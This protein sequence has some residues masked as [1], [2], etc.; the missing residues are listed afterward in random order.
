[1][2]LVLFTKSF[3]YDAAAEQTFILGELPYLREIFD[4]IILIPKACDGKKFSLNTHIDV[5]EGYAKFLNRRSNLLALAL[6]AITSRY[7]Y[8]E[9]L[10]YPKIVFAPFK[11]LKLLKFSGRVEITVRWMENWLK[12]SQ[13]DDRLVLYSYWF[14]DLAAGLT[15]VKRLYPQFKL[16]SRA[17]GYDIYEELYFPYYW[18]LRRQALAGLDKLFPVSYDGRDYFRNRYPEFYDLFETAHLGVKDPGFITKS[19]ADGVFR[20]VSCATIVPLKRIDLLLE[21]IAY[22]ARIRPEQKFEWHHFGDGQARRKLQK[23]VKN[24]FP[25]NAIGCLPGHVPNQDVLRHYRENPIDVFV[26]LS[27]T[28]AVPVSIMEA[29]SYGI[30]IIATNVGGNSEIVS[31]RNGLLLSPNPTPEEVAQAFL[32]ICDYPKTAYEMRKESR[33]VWRKSYNA[34]V[35]FRNFA[36]RLKSIGE[37]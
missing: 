7:L 3:P 21:G 8:H 9:L 25:R 30:P 29:I 26:N 2:I 10:I 15:L 27:T 4:Q 14:E 20:I 13:L 37:S 28:E 23:A 31:E 33:R 16:V 32:T 5:E 1:M 24:K 35:N 22:A 17:H 18:P 36:E 19:S 6:H 11:L 34:D 12:D